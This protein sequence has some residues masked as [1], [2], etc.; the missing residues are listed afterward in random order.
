[1]PYVKNTYKYK[2]VIEVENVHAGKLGK[3]GKKAEK[4]KPTPEE[5]EAI[6]MRN[7]I[8]LLRRTIDANYE[9]EDLWITLTYRRNKRPTP[10]DAHRIMKNYLARMR[11]EYRKRGVEMKYI[12]INEYTRTAIH[13]H[14]VLNDL[15]DGSG[16][17]VA[18]RQWHE[19]GTNHKYLYE[20]G[21]YEMLASYIVK[22]TG[23]HFGEDGN[24]AKVL[25]SCSRNLIRPEKETEIM[26]RDDWPEEPRVPKGYVL[27]KDSLHNGINKLG[28]RYQYYRLIRIAPEKGKGK[29][30]GSTKRKGKNHTQRDAGHQKNGP[31]ADR[32]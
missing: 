15:P 32:G 5:M 11:A 4:K 9:K 8:K 30:R 19:G 3:G 28:Y 12:L 17:K 2:N 18:H 24:P 10:E 29:K 20:D 26:K 27:E 1:M 31:S 7:K 13:H 22:E 14:L 6:N 25:Y 21:R 16:A 23:K